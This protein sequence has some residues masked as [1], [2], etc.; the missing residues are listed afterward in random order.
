MEQKWPF[1]RHT[2]GRSGNHNR[3]HIHMICIG[4]QASRFLEFGQLPRASMKHYLKGIKIPWERFCQ[5]TSLFVGWK[6]ENTWL[7]FPGN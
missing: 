5:P 4:L 3:L 2:F 1:V 7:I 6:K